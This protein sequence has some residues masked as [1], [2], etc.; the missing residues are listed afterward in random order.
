MY[1]KDFILRML[2]MIGDLVAG[3]FGLIKKGEFQQASQSLNNAYFEFLKNDAAL[4]RS[5]PKEKLTDELVREHNYTNDHLE[6][7]SELFYAE[8]E[9]LFAKESHPDSLEYYEKTLVLLEFVNKESNSFS[10]ERQSKTGLI[11]D[12]IVQLKDGT[13]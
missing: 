4:F 2:E 8:A 3:I 12:R 1:Q 7:L 6:I 11:Q 13:I 10:I 5:I 9:L